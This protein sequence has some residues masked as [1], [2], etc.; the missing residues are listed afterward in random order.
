MGKILAKQVLDVM[1][2]QSD[3]KIKGV[4]VFMEK[5]IF[6]SGKQKHHVVNE[7][8]F[9]YWAMNFDRLNEEGNFRMGVVEGKLV[10]QKFFKEDWI[11][12]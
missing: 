9:I 1:D 4:K 12:I 11:T 7:H 3:Q 5:T 2:Q 10:Q 6:D 8:G